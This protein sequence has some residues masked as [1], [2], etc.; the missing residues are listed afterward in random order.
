MTRLAKSALA[1]A[2]ALGAT[3][4]GAASLSPEARLDK[5]LAGRVAGTP[6][7]CLN[8]RD[9]QG[10]QIIDKTAIVYRVGNKLYVNRPRGG[11]YQLDDDDILVTKT[12]GTQLCRI[13]IVRLVEILLPL[14]AEARRP[15]D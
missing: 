14:S 8:L 10:S 12:I 3:A 9:I 11:A 1:A 13:D 7:N 6:V 2:V 4:A 15:L 5:L